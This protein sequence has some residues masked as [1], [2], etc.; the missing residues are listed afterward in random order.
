MPQAEYL[1]SKLGNYKILT[2]DTGLLNGNG[3]K[4]DWVTN[5]LITY[6]PTGDVLFALNFNKGS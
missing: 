5:N 6:P 1:L 2:T 3:E 4:V